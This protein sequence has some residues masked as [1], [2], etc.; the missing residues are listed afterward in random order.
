MA[1]NRFQT[2]YHEYHATPPPEQKTDQPLVLVVDDDISVRQ[3]LDY[4][5][6]KE[7]YRVFLCKNG[8]EGIHHLSQDVYAVVL[9]IKMPG[10]DG[11]QVYEE[12]KTT[13][14]DVPIIFYSAY[15]NMMEDRDIQ[16]RYNPF[17]YVNK[18]GE[19]QTLLSSLQRAVSYRK[20]NLTIQK[21]Q[22]ELD[23]LKKRRQHT[24]H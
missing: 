3:T 6:H 1:F 22:R 14:P 11:L 5:L 7:G 23:D 2:L 9:D 24:S 19:T 12:M 4:L 21:T 20:T 10:K 13:F 17:S 18:D 8:D 16:Y 15:Q